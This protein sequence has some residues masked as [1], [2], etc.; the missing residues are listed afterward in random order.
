MFSPG[1]HRKFAKPQTMNPWSATD[2]CILIIT[3]NSLCWSEEKVN[4]LVRPHR[5]ILHYTCQHNVKL[6]LQ[7]VCN[8][9]KQGCQKKKKTKRHFKILCAWRVTS[10]MFR[11]QGPEILAPRICEPLLERWRLSPIQ[12]TFIPIT[13]T[14]MSEFT[15]RRPLFKFLPTP[16]ITNCTV[17][18]SGSN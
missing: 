1:S 15:Y 6:Q 14:L 11:T 17:T 12:I 3:S 7:R 5:N 16:Y 13:V 8:A 9:W 2:E 4:A 10:R 18:V